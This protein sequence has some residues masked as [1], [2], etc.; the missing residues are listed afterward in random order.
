[1]KRHKEAV[2]PRNGNEIVP[3]HCCLLTFKYFKE[4]SLR[5]QWYAN[6]TVIREGRD[7]LKME[8]NEGILNKRNK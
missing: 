1:M 8:L 2:S 6:S 7:V 4:I 5:A 3:K